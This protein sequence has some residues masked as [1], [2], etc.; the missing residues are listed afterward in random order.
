VLNTT[1]SF[2]FCRC[3]EFGSVQVFYPTGSDT[4]PSVVPGPLTPV[5][6][7]PLEKIGII[8]FSSGVTLLR[9][10]NFPCQHL[11]LESTNARSL[12]KATLKLLEKLYIEDLPFNVLLTKGGRVYV[13]VRRAQRISFIGGAEGLHFALAE[14][15]GLLVCFS[16]VSFNLLD[17]DTL[18]KLIK[19]DVSVDECSFKEL[20]FYMLNRKL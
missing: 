13:H 17:Y 1:V 4:R 5:Q 2:I 15:I 19:A 11:V 16:E 7:A 18:E 14:S 10:R 3:V 12:Q 8:P 6:L 9:T 20:L